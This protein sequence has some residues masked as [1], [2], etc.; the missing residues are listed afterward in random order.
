MVFISGAGECYAINWKDL[1]QTPDQQA[2]KAMKQGDYKS[3][4]KKFN[5]RDWIGAAKYRSGEFS[6]AAETFSANESADGHYNRGNA[7][8][9]SGDLE[10]ALKAYEGLKRTKSKELEKDLFEKLY[11]ELKQKRGNHENK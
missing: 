11:P 8:A 10:G 5:N 9:K 1:W 3:A 7:L 6:A 2:I 4:S